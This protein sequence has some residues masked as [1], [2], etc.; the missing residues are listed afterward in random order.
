MTIELR[1]VTKKVR[2]GAIRVTYEDINIR[3]EEK[4]NVAF[5]GHK[6]AGLSAIADLI[7][8]ADAPD[9]GTVR[10]THSISWVIPSSGFIHKHHALAASARFIA[11]LYEADE[12]EFL[13]KISEA[14][15]LGDVLNVRGDLCPKDALQRF[16]F[17]A[18]VCL[19]F[20]RY[21]FSGGFMGGK[22]ERERRA[23][24]LNDLSTRAGLLLVTQDIKSAQQ[25][26]DQAYVFDS[27]RA[28]YFDNME[29]ASEF[30]GA[31]ASQGGGDD[32][33]FDSEPELQ[34]LV[35]MDF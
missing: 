25:F 12:K 28:T 3:I 4:A 24:V 6:E 32:D 9:K 5:L 13:A 23:E 8:G 16:S 14:A 20:D 1:D 7:C 33:F 17:Y 27:G 10:R 18:G 30:F 21:I 2:Q 19:P 29:A 15:E 26:C 22:D 34:E 35:N 11:R 31:I